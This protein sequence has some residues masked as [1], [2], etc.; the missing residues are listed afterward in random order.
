[1][2]DFK[3]L[4]PSDF[5]DL[6][7]ALLQKELGVTL[8]S[9]MAGRDGGID[10][11]YA[12]G[13]GGSVVIQAKHF[14]NSSFSSL[15]TELKKERVKLGKMKKPPSQYIL[16]TSLGLSPDR[17]SEI[18]EIL[19]PFVVESGDIY[20]SSDL[21]NLLIKFPEV[22]RQ[23]YKLWITS[24]EVLQRVL[25]NDIYTNAEEEAK[26]IERSVRLYV[27]TG[28]LQV[29]LDHLN[30]FHL[31]IISGA[32]G[33]GKSTLAR[34]LAWHF[35][36]DKWQLVAVD[37]FDQAARI[38]IADTKQVFFFDDFMGQ[39]RL[40]SDMINRT[41]EKL[42][43][44]IGR[45]QTSK[46]KRFVLTSREYIIRQAQI[47]SEK[48][49]SGAVD[50]RTYTLDIG[51]YTKGYRARI[52]YNHIYYSDLGEAY[53]ARLLDE[54]FY[55]NIISHANFSP[56][57]VEALTSKEIAERQEPDN[58][59]GWV[60]DTLDR[61]DLLW[62][63]PYESHLSRAGKALVYLMYFAFD[64]ISIDVLKTD[65]LIFYEALA[66]KYN[67]SFDQHDFSRAVKETEGTFVSITNGEAMF[68][69]PSL[70]DFLSREIAGSDDICLLLRHTPRFGLIKLVLEHVIAFES[71]YLRIAPQI[72]AAVADAV[73]WM[74]D[75]PCMVDSED[76]PYKVLLHP[77]PPERLDLTFKFW[78][79]FK[80]KALL[81]LMVSAATKYNDITTY[82]PFGKLIE[83]ITLAMTSSDRPPNMQE[84]IDVVEGRLFERPLADDQVSPHDLSEMFRVIDGLN[85]PK[86]EKHIEK[87][88][89]SAEDAFSEITE[90]LDTASS[91]SELEE[92]EGYL[93]YLAGEA[94]LNYSDVVDKIEERRWQL[95]EMENEDHDHD[96]HD[97]EPQPSSDS[98]SSID[99]LFATLRN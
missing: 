99:S 15:K 27:D 76:G 36:S 73:A 74:I 72:S 8:E 79:I 82:V 47:Q 2:Y 37:D 16:T 23:T 83:P 97:Y 11:R 70:R 62:K 57:I 96:F 48:L 49:S 71:D 7:R 35:M 45:L 30:K 41:D 80:D 29:A 88:K 20:G 52:L 43:R 6:S 50:L 64:E 69:N 65:F 94:G 46:D 12:R 21:N 55:K 32:P 61:P 78:Q 26:R 58:Y 91:T 54:K 40:T 85:Y 81:P 18:E 60:L 44:F 4:S 84:I 14:A 86:S 13:S 19:N 9:F 87:M 5:E 10:L 24:A 1:M 53:K 34:I 25:H 33:V 31:V 42:I 89:A 75:L 59:C 38:Y 63:L 68:P 90:E 56:R 66:K 77:T 3:S 51:Q 39:I 93:E 98:D 92:M 67:F 17:K 95:H 22:E 28:A